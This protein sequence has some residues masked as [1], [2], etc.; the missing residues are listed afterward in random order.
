MNKLYRNKEWLKN[1]YINEKLSTRQIGRLVNVDN[2]TIRYWLK[3][4]NIPSRSITP[5]NIKYR[6]KVWLENKYI[7][8]KLSFPQIAKLCN[9]SIS[10][11][12]NWMGR[13]YIVSRSSGEGVHLALENNCNLSIEAIHWLYG[14]LLGDG[15][16]QSYCPYSARICYSSK[17]PEYIEYVRDTLKSFGIEQSGKIRKNHL[18]DRGM[19]CYIYQYNSLTYSELL[20]IY[21]R[22]YPN[23]KKIVPRDIVLTPL[24]CRQWYIGDGCLT[25]HKDS[26][27]SIVLATNGFS[28]YDVKWVTKQLNKIGFKAKRTIQN[29]IRISVYSTKDF[30]EYIG[31]CPVECY[32]YKWEY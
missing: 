26:R 22:W 25:H 12:G 2:K 15:C 11:V 7:N 4:Y 32:Q 8:E 9:V 24:V 23:G 14:E 1:K 18:T 6:N 27:P 29:A 10:T 28:I 5:E 17:Y 20:S 30:L 31:N 13:Y 19:D 16:L 3:K 21:R